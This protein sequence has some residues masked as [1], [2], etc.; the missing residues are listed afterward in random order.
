MTWSSTFG[1]VDRQVQV[2]GPA[3]LAYICGC[4]P[5]SQVSSRDGRPGVVCSIRSESLSG[6]SSGVVHG[7]HL[8]SGSD[9]AVRQRHRGRRPQFRRAARHDYG[10]H[11]AQR[12]RQDHYVAGGARPGPANRGQRID[13]R[14]P[15]R[16]PGPANSTRGCRSGSVRLPSGTYGSRPSSGSRQ[17]RRHS[18]GPRRR[19][20]RRGWRRLVPSAPAFDKSTSPSTPR[21]TQ[22]P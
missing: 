21:T 13:R 20:A 11:R 2:V 9:Q 15:V 10:L 17:Q 5:P 22:P 14:C 16:A 18:R 8:C 6:S 4:M 1:V 7:R 19:R 12:C 3:G